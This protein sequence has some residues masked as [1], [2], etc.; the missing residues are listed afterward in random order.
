MILTQKK[1]TE[2]PQLVYHRE[3]I[4]KSMKKLLLII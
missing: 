2:T 4:E 3:L 1:A